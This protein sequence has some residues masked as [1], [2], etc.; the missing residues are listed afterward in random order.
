MVINPTLFA[1]HTVQILFVC[2]IAGNILSYVRP[3]FKIQILPQEMDRNTLIQRS[4]GQQKWFLWYPAHWNSNN[5]GRAN[6]SQ[7]CVQGEKGKKNSSKWYLGTLAYNKMNIRILVFQY[8]RGTQ[9]SLATNRLWKCHKRPIWISVCRSCRLGY[10][11]LSVSL[12][13]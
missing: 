12:S 5:W 2:P 9:V 13:S 8:L 10:S 1:L 11:T 3:A 4:P 7:I 6:M